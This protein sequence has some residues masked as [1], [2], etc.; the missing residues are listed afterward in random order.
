MTDAIAPEQWN[1]SHSEYARETASRLIKILSCGCFEKRNINADGD[2]AENLTEHH[3]EE[4][5]FLGAACLYHAGEADE[6]RYA[7]TVVEQ[8][9]TLDQEGSILRQTELAEDTGGGDGIGGGD[10]TAEHQ[11]YGKGEIESEQK[12]RAVDQHTVEYRAEQGTYQREH[13]DLSCHLF[14]VG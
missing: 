14:E 5:L 4:A 13:G 3:G 9:F 2:R 1:T 10:D 12:A 8:G 6:Q 11:A 7:D